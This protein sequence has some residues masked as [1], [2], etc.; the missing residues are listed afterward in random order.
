LYTNQYNETIEK[1]KTSAELT[2]DYR[3]SKRCEQVL[4]QYDRESAWECLQDMLRE[5]KKQIEA[6]SPFR[7]RTLLSNVSSEDY[8]DNSIWGQIAYIYQ[9]IPVYVMLRD[10]K[11]DGVKHLC[12]WLDHRRA[13]YY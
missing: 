12:E 6:C 3:N 13:Q 10:G 5:Y 4:R 2:K 11:K 7:E 9:R 1:M 8:S